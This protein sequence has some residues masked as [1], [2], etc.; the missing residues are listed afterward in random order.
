MYL[1][2]KDTSQKTLLVQI[3]ITGSK[4]KRLAKDR[5]NEFKELV[6]SIPITEL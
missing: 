4:E 5:H 6:L 1:N 2:I 3:E